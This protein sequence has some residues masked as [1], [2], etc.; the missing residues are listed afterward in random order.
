MH[1]S[2]L[3]DRL[4]DLIPIYCIE[5]K[6]YP[7]WLA[8]QSNTDQAWLSAN[9]CSPTGKK[10]CFLPDSQGNIKAVIHLVEDYQSR[11]AYASLPSVLPRGNYRYEGFNDEQY[12]CAAIA[13]GLSLYQFTR[14]K[15]VDV[16]KKA[17]EPKLYL[18]ETV[19]T[20][21]IV[22]EVDATYLVR[23]LINTPAEDMGPVDLIRA[24]EKLA[25]EYGGNLHTVVGDALLEAGFPAIHAVGRGSDKQ[26]ALID[27]T[28]G[29]PADFRLTLVGKGV[30]FDS[31]GLNIKVGNGMR[32]MKKDMGG[33]AHVLG[34]AQWIMAMHLPVSLRVIIGAAENMISGNAYRPGD[35]LS[36]RKGITVEIGNTDAEGRLVLA[37]CLTLACETPP[38]LLIDFATLTGASR[39]ALGTDVP[40]VFTQCAEWGTHLQALSAQVDDLVWPM[41]LYAPY[42]DFLQSTVADMT[43]DSASPYGGAITAA[44]FL[45]EFIDPA[46][47]WLHLDVMAFNPKSRAGRPEGGEAMGMRAVYALINEKV[48]Y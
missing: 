40:S 31:G 16:D 48:M 17:A 24:S 13:W 42:K 29:N 32:L 8:T 10:I 18:P 41:P 44:L 43:N 39:V 20:K 36:T 9:A 33:A 26:P 1:S 15:T 38:D 46:V 12:T 2:Y 25:A 35:V 4:P 28:W 22:A 30:C 14:Y 47:P 7:E 23:D 3:H 27:F 34:L 5:K 37:D 6:S 11:W 45:K 19:H 21:N